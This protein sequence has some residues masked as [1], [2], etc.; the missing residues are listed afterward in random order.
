M[1]LIECATCNKTYSDYR[2]DGLC[3]YCAVP[4]DEQ[5]EAGLDKAWQ[6][7][8][9]LHKRKVKDTWVIAGL[10]LLAVIFPIL[11]VILVGGLMSWFFVLTPLKWLFGDK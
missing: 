3:P 7:A 10:I 2:P 8:E 5:E 4:V 6:E 9:E 11:L 1:A